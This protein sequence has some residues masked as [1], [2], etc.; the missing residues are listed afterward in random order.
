M[1]VTRLTL[2]DFRSYESAEL[3]PGPSLTVIAG[4]NGALKAELD[5]VLGSAIAPA[6]PVAA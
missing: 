6:E 3:R 2:R 1:R 5:R 4:R